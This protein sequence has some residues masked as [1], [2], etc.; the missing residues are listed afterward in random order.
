ML[1]T[2]KISLPDPGEGC[3]W[4]IADTGSSIHVANHALHFPGAA[5]DP[6]SSGA[7]Y[8]SATGDPFKNMGHFPVDF[9]TENFHHRSVTFVNGN[10]STP[11]ISIPLWA[12]DGNRSIFDAESGE[13]IQ[14][15][16]G[17][18]D[19]IVAKQSIYF[20]KLKVGQQVL[21]PPAGDLGFAWT[22]HR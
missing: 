21:K 20:L 18:S 10:V 17:E 11:I 13:T 8:A 14:L 5:L 22:M 1:E 2:G 4:A 3:V 16:S 19:P 12:K 7:T 9:R 6:T 15:S